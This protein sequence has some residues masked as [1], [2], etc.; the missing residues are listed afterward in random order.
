[1][2]FIIRLINWFNRARF[3]LRYAFWAVLNSVAISAFVYSLFNDVVDGK[4]NV[5]PWGAA[6]ALT[7]LALLLLS[8]FEMLAAIM[9]DCADEDVFWVMVFKALMLEQYKRYLYSPKLTHAV[10]MRIAEYVQN[11]NLDDAPLY[12]YN[13]SSSCGFMYKSFIHGDYTIMILFGRM[14]VLGDVRDMHRKDCNTFARDIVNNLTYSNRLSKTKV[15]VLGE[16]KNSSDT[17]DSY[18]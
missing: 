3:G 2:S 14:Y 15:S 11:E 4:G 10:K 18:W 9:F 7:F 8:L 6:L 12:M 17:F 16:K 5:M 13:F 1:M